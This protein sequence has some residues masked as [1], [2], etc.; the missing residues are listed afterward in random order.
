MI[1]GSSIGLLLAL[2]YDH[3]EFQSAQTASLSFSGA[4]TKMAK[5]LITA[6]LT[7]SSAIPRVFIK[8]IASLLSFVGANNRATSHALQSSLSF[9]ANTTK[10]TPR[11]FNAAVSFIG[12]HKGGKIYFV[13]AS[14]IISFAGSFKKTIIKVL[15]GTLSPFSTINR[16]IMVYIRS[17]LVFSGV[18]SRYI[19]PHFTFI[20]SIIGTLRQEATQNEIT[21]KEVG[22]SATISGIDTEDTKESLREE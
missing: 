7:L 6:V 20:K 10:R 14:A 1:R 16:Y 4:L 11:Y 21:T 12:F 8:G 17:N 18:L 5:R 19:V 3:S 9:L 22:S 15:Y 2:T 13:V